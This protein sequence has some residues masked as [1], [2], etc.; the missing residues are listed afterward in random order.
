MNEFINPKDITNVNKN[1]SANKA[2]PLHT[3]VYQIASGNDK[4]SSKDSIYQRIEAITPNELLV[5]IHESMSAISEKMAR[6]PENLKHDVINNFNE[7]ADTQPNREILQKLIK[8]VQI[9]QNKVMSG[10][11]ELI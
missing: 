4:V 9:G 6:L 8:D 3:E 2:K 10:I 7:Y 11:K 5:K 1:D